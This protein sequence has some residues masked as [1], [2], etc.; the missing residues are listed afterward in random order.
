MKTKTHIYLGS[1]IACRASHPHTWQFKTC[2]GQVFAP[3]YLQQC[4]PPRED[5]YLKDPFR[6]QAQEY[7]YFF[8]KNQCPAMTGL[9]LS[10]VTAV[11][12][13]PLGMRGSV[14]SIGRRGEN[15]CSDCMR[16]DTFPPEGSSLLSQLLYFLFSAVQDDLLCSTGFGV[17]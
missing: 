6:S 10:H 7:K 17:R 1:I 11:I 8:G 3:T 2:L 5:M 13:S 12:V 15:R 4:Q 16:G 9:S 14:E